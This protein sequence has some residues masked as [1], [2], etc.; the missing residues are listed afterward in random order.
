MTLSHSSFSLKRCNR[1]CILGFAFILVS[2]L[3]GRRAL[4]QTGRQTE[5]YRNPVLFADYSDPDVI[6]DG[7]H[8]YLVASSFEFVPGIPV[9]ESEDLVHW[10]IVTHVVTRLQMSPAYS[11][12]GGETRYGGGVWA[13]AVR[14]H[15]GLFYVYFPTP[16]EGIFVATAPHMTGPWSQPVAV[17]AMPGLEDPCPFWDDDGKAYLIHSK[18]GAGPLILHRMSAD[19][20]HL[21]DE[22]RIIVQDPVHLPTLEGPKLYKRDGWYY[23]FAPMGGVST[24]DQVVGRSRD[25]YGPYEWRHVLTQGS[26]HV[27][28][29]HQGAWV[30]TPDG[31]SWFVH[32]QQRGAHGRIIWLEPMMWKDGWPLMGKLLPGSTVGEPVMTGPM[33]VEISNDRERPQTSDEFNTPV[34]S[35]MWEWNHNPDDSRWSVTEHPGF[36]RLHPGLAADLLHARNTLTECMQDESLE[37]TT[38]LD[39]S[40]MTDGDHAGLSVFERS[41]SQIG[42]MQQG[43]KRDLYFSSG[44]VQTAGPSL[45]E[46][47]A[48]I[49][50]RARV[51]VDIATYSYSLDDGVTFVP[52]GSPVKLVFSWWKGARPSL[53]AYN[54]E[55][56]SAG[57]ADFDWLHY[58]PLPTPAAATR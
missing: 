42:I 31:R 51:D 5:E 36:L 1:I 40:G 27:N 39:T 48:N 54:T 55:R 19:G 23:I 34:L 37:V 25:I 38:R 26:T 43:G 29:P 47:R 45:P 18:K 52:L 8:F 41:L 44:T 3:A 57:H 14:F 6:R 12:V 20:K 33:P 9:L 58:T 4:A 50:L 15:H 24:G 7:S 35:Q 10:R 16:T 28:G 32:F 2:L 21:L 11:M 13:P 30:E 22:G 17:L 56:V 49:Q 46:G 53:F